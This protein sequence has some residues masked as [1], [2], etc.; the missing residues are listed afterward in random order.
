MIHQ[1]VASGVKAHDC[2]MAQ[3]RVRVREVNSQTLR[4]IWRSARPQWGQEGA[5]LILQTRS[6]PD[7]LLSARTESWRK[8]WQSLQERDE[9][10]GKELIETV[11]RSQRRR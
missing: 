3:S 10:E 11:L 7:S 6:S 1:R 2:D 4:T 8:D 5:V 9:G